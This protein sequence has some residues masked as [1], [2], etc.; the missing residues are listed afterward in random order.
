MLKAMPALL[1]QM[2][3]LSISLRHLA[4]DHQPLHVRHR[5]DHRLHGERRRLPGRQRQ[6]ARV[7]PYIGTRLPPTRSPSVLGRPLMPCYRGNPLKVGVASAAALLVLI[8]LAITI[9]A[10]FGLA[11]QPQPLPARPGLRGQGSLHRR[12]RRHPGRRC[13]DRGP[14]RR[15]GHRGRGAG[16]A[17]GGEHAGRAALRPAAPASPRPA[18]ATRP[19]WHK[20]TSRSAPVNGGREIA[21]RRPDLERQHAQPG[22]LR[23]VPERARPGDPQPPADADPAGGWRAA[24]PAT[25]NQRPAEPGCT[26]CRRNRWRRCR[27]STSTIRTS[28]GS[29]PTWPWSAIAWRR[30]TSSWE[31]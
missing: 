5:H 28:T 16:E 30:A 14:H 22:R 11:F 25:G 8:V 29:S 24:G 13:C 23:P 15:P 17:G 31:I 2:Q 12:Q 4:R 7:H 20:S 26:A 3:A 10:S 19:C 18:S 9:N 6:H 1:D 27:H 21:E